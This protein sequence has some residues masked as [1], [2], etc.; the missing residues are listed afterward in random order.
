MTAT[1]IPDGVYFLHPDGSAW[2]AAV[3]RGGEWVASVY[4]ATAE[5]HAAARDDLAGIVPADTD[6]PVED[7]AVCNQIIANV[8]GKETDPECVSVSVRGDER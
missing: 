3:Y 5:T 7:L 8:F 1:E 2:E 6:E 4:E